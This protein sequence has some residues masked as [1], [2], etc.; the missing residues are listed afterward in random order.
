M[1]ICP[2]CGFENI[3]GADSCEKCHQPLSSLSK[4]RPASRLEWCVMKNR[5]EDLVPREPFVVSAA[6]PVG[7]VLRQMVA[8]SIGSVVVMENRQVAGIFTERD[9]LYRL[10]D[11]AADLADRPVSEFMS[12]PVETVGMNDRVAFALHKMDLGGYR[13]LPVVDQQGRI[14][15]II[16]V[17]DILNHILAA[18]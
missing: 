11:Q 15:G 7:Q 1:R 14:T 10:N 4:P 2:D 6:N 16:S 13:H 9:A 5:I 18:V 12:S 3:E 17:R 8:R